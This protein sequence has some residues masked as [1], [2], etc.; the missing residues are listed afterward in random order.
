MSE[1]LTALK[2]SIVTTYK[3]IIAKASQD[4]KDIWAKDKGFFILFGALILTIKFRQILMNL[5]I[6]NAKALFNSAQKQS[7][8]DQTKENQANT[9]ANALEQQAEQLPSQEQP[10][11]PDWNKKQ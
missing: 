8:Q 9:Q 7:N 5:I 10:I 3:G 2:T 4:I 1:K 11:T 6:G